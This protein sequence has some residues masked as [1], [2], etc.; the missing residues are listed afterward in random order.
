MKSFEVWKIKNY[1]GT[2]TFPASIKLSAEDGDR[3]TSIMT[4]LNTYFTEQIYLFVDGSRPISEWKSFQ[5]ELD[6]FGLSE[7]VAIWQAEYD[8]YIEKNA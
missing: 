6:S 4:D 5:S 3:A 1:D 7:V 2:Y 8:K